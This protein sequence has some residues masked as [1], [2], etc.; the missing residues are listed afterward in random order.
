MRTIW[1]STGRFP[2]ETATP[3][4]AWLCRRFVAQHVDQ[5]A[6]FES[7]A[8]RP[9]VWPGAWRRSTADVPVPKEPLP[10]ES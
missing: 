3:M 7:S 6:Y 2:G 1:I 8:A 10:A 9:R 4:A 5:P